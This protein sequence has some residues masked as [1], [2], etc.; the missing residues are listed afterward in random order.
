MLS[1]LGNRSIGI[2]NKFGNGIKDGVQKPW[3]YKELAGQVGL[4]MDTAIGCI[5]QLYMQI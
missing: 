4:L 1:I 2:F 3:H 5:P